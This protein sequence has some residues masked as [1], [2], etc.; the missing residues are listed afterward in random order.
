MRHQSRSA[1]NVLSSCT[2]LREDEH[3]AAQ[4]LRPKGER[5]SRQ[6]LFGH[7]NTSIL[8]TAQFHLHDRIDAF[9]VLDGLV[10]GEVAL[11]WVTREPVPTLRTGDVVVMDNLTCH[12]NSNVLRAIRATDAH[13]FFLP[14][15]SPEPE[16]DQAFAK[17]RYRLRNTAARSR[18]ALWRAVGEVLDAIEP[19]EP[20]KL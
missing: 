1:R 14:P 19:H 16:P 5:L 15:Y 18:E 8:I 17:I 9:W 3:G 12:K 10:N 7:W 20:D 11:T 2:R 4:G 13:V 6:A